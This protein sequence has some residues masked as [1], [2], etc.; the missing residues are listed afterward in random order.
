MTKKKKQFGIQDMEQELFGKN[1]GA[2][3]EYAREFRKLMNKQKKCLH[4][5]GMF[6]HS[7]SELHDFSRPGDIDGEGTI[8]GYYDHCHL[9]GIRITKEIIKKQMKEK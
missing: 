2:R 1:T 5:L 9:C 3:K 8:A 7:S 4:V 6:F